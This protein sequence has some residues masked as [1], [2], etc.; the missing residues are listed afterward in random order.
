MASIHLTTFAGLNTAVSPRL[1]KK[2]Y[3][4]IAHNC[5]LWDGAIRPMAKW[6]NLNISDTDKYSIDIAE[7][8]ATFVLSKMISARHMDSMVYPKGTIIGLMPFQI[9]GGQSNIGYQNYASP[10][11]TIY[12]VGVAPPE[13]STSSTITYTAQHHSKKPVNRV[14]GVTSV[15]K[16]GDYIEES[17]ISLIPN[18]S[19]K[20]TIYEGD[21]ALVNVT[22]VGGGFYERT[23]HRLYRSV[24]GM[25][26]GHSV[27][28]A[29]DTEWHLVAELHHDYDKPGLSRNYK[30]HDAGS[31][32]VL[33]FDTL[34]SSRFY[35]PRATTWRYITIADSGWIV[36][37]QEGG[38]IAVSERN[39]VHAWPTENYFKV[40]S[41]ITGLVAHYD[42][43]YIGTKDQPYIMTLSFNEHTAL[44][45]SIQPFPANYECLSKTMVE[46]NA[47]AMYATNA[48]LV[49]LTRDGAKLLT[50]GVASSLRPLYHTQYVDDS[51]G[52]P[53]TQCVDINFKDTTYGAYLNGDYFGFCSV[54][55]TDGLTLHIGYLYTTGNSLDGDHPL[56][57]LVT[58]DPPNAQVLDHV[59][60]SNGLSVLTNAPTPSGGDPNTLYNN[61]WTMPFPN[62]KQGEMY[63][64]A[65]K[66]CY[67]WKSKKFVFPGITTLGYAKVV[68]DGGHVRLRIFV[69]C[70]CTYE[71]EVKSCRPFTLPPNMVG[72]EWEVEV[73]GTAVIHE[74]HL[75][76]S[77]RE[78][79]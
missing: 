13:I 18:Q 48:G 7:D 63:N 26:T 79:V 4:Q 50:A 56:Q 55:R 35:P 68:H 16:T 14:Y 74:I 11:D 37:A 57:R 70:N 75:A 15:R 64:Q 36:A 69:D 46:T 60:S 8:D 24:S 52:T 17:S 42:N 33:P 41:V 58:F 31:A 49:S 12:E 78:L 38:E 40:P 45:A 3:A 65:Q 30:Y 76:P 39:M 32:T 43:V 27:G 54:P 1:T 51:G 22:I 62:T 23:S 2:E 10:A 77:L 6:V 53:V 19:V 59:Q 29:F 61:A 47:G 5:L 25:D 20:D 21:L 67:T 71:T 72:V 44:Q 66:M 28:N 9:Q 34:L 73:E